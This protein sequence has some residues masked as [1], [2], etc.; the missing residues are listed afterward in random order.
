MHAIRALDSIAA[1]LPATTVGTGD[2]RPATDLRFL[3]QLEPGQHLRAT[4]QASLSSTKFA[5]M[6]S[7]DS[8]N[9]LAG[10]IVHMKL[11]LGDTAGRSLESRFYQSRASAPFRP[12]HR[13][14]SAGGCSPLKRN[15]SLY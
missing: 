9:G 1:I 8:E 15:Q 5:V 3:P 11:P 14:A 12:G 13:P 7:P 6:L 2:Q 4:V 10:Q